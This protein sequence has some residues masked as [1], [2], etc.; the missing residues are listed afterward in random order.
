MT[1]HGRIRR[2]QGFTWILDPKDRLQSRILRIGAHEGEETSILP[3]LVHEG[4]VVFDIGAN[5]GYYTLLLSRL[6]GTGGQVHALEPLSLSYERLVWHV[7]NNGRTNVTTHRLAA[8]NTRCTMNVALPTWTGEINWG[9]FHLFDDCNG[10]SADGEI[11]DVVRIDD[12]VSELRLGPVAFIKID[13]EGYEP[14]ILEGAMKTITKF[15]PAMIVEV[16]GKNLA[17]A[18][19][20]VKSL[21]EMLRGFGYNVQRLKKHS[22]EM[23][24][25]TERDLEAPVHFNA[26]CT[27]AIAGSGLPR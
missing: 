11:I 1:V 18:G 20:D 15:S 8:G 26:I 6:V 12:L 13:A 22:A 5:I 3:D 25:V 27:R 21:I 17:R 24:E 19:S 16:L 10:N 4:N 7:R 9:G 14:Y 2:A 23:H